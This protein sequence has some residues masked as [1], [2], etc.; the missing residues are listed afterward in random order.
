MTHHIA[1]KRAIRKSVHQAQGLSRKAMDVLRALADRINADGQCW[2][3]Q[4]TIAE[5]ARLSP[6]SVWSALEELEASGWIGRARRH[7][8]NGYRSS[9]LITVRT[10][11]Q[12]AAWAKRALESLVDKAKRAL[13]LRVGQLAEFAKRN[14][15][16]SFLNPEGLATVTVE[17]T[18]ARPP[19]KSGERP[20]PRWGTPQEMAA[21]MR[22][23]AT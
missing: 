15:L 6:R 19:H 8:R 3:S 23:I 12:A 20:N 2:P 22:R 13:D 14:P 7:K 9:D 17:G 21:Y 11:T 1:L 4:R 5:D 18:A 16:D 10:L